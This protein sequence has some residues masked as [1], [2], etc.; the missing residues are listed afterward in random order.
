MSGSGRRIRTLTNRVRVCRA[1]LTQ[2]RIGKRH[3]N[4]ASEACQAFF[5]F[6]PSK[7]LRLSIIWPEKGIEVIK[8]FCQPKVP[9]A[10]GG[11]QSAFFSGGSGADRGRLIYNI[12]LTGAGVKGGAYAPFIEA[13][14]F[15]RRADSRPPA[16][17][18][19]TIAIWTC[20]CCCFIGAG[21]LSTVLS[22]PYRCNQPQAV[23]DLRL[24][25]ES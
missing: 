10:Y 14:F 12:T 25:L 6:L 24:R 19:K 3:Y 18:S 8:G 1:T 16:R 13:L 23:S 4:I 17:S 7:F 15:G 5:K 22:I 9:M 11:K 21:H 20:S 2:F